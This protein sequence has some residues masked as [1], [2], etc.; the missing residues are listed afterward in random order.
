MK[1]VTHPSRPTSD[2]VPSRTRH[3][4]HGDGQTRRSDR[5]AARHARH[6]PE[7]VTLTSPFSRGRGAGGTPWG[8]AD[9]S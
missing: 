6:A 4:R 1:P 2:G 7:P 5:H 8:V 3:A 9:A